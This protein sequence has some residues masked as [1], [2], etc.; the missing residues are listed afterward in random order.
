MQYAFD[1]IANRFAGITVQSG[2]YRTM[3]E[4]V[5]GEVAAKTGGGFEF[6]DSTVVSFISRGAQVG[7]FLWTSGGS[8]QLLRVS[9][10]AAAALGVAA[11]RGVGVITEDGIDS[12]YLGPNLNAAVLRSQLRYKL[13]R[14]YG[15]ER[16]DF[17]DSAGYQASMIADD[18]TADALAD[19]LVRW[20]ADRLYQV[21]IETDWSGC[22]LQLGRRGGVRLRLAAR[23]QTTALD[24]CDGE[25]HVHRERGYIFD[26]GELG[27]P[28][29][30]RDRQRRPHADWR[31]G[32]YADRRFER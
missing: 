25:L 17:T 10:V 14:D 27:R 24:R 19:H 26:A 4:S 13:T 12:W 23:G 7:D 32:M 29:L 2:A 9:S 22:D 16:G 11:A 18:F 15:G 1:P 20:H 6:T 21:Q 5:N 3:Q 31:R 8:G 30:S 28:A